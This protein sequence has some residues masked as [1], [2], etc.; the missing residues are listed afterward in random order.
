MFQSL[1]GLILTRFLFEFPG[2]RHQF[3]SLK[4]LILT[5]NWP[6]DVT[7]S[8]MFQSLKGLILTMQPQ[9][10]RPQDH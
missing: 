10:Y 1:K 3:Q 6:A 4:G 5:W 2:L 8:Y 9:A 7:K